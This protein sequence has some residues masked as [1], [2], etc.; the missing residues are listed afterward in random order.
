MQQN[1]LKAEVGRIM[2]TKILLSDASGFSMGLKTPTFLMPALW[3]AG[4]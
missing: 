1:R 3:T 4:K 2:K